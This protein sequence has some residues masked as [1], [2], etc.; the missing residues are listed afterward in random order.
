MR[1]SQRARLE[2][3]RRIGWFMKQHDVLL[4]K[5][6]ESRLRTELDE[7]LLTLESLAKEQRAAHAELRKHKGEIGERRRELLQFH[8][9]PVATIANARLKGASRRAELTPVLH[10]LRGADLLTA[11]ERMVE[12]AAQHRAVFTRNQLRPSFLSELRGAAAALALAF[13]ARAARKLR[14]TTVT[15]RIR[16][17]QREARMLLRVL[18]AVIVSHIWNNAELLV[19]WHVTRKVGPGCAKVLN[20]ALATN[21][22][23]EAA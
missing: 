7:T 3:L 21:S 6:N 13:D 22:G 19:A 4:G 2:A 1:M 17:E 8:M 9:R 12:A 11:A 16:A 10:G 23:E 18:N 20:S 15:A 5:I 14:L